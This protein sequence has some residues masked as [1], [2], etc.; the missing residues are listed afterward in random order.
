MN[1]QQN[2]TAGLD[3][4]HAAAPV[5]PIELGNL[6]VA[7]LSDLHR[8]AGD[9]ADDFRACRDAFAA[10]LDRYGRTRHILALLGDAEDLWECRPAEVIARYRASILLEKAFHDQGRY[11]RFLGNHDQAWQVPELAG[12]YLEP[13]LGRVMPL[14]LL[15]L[16]VTERGRTSRGD[17]PGSRP[18]G[19]PVGGS[20]GVVQPQVSALRL[21]PDPA[22]GE[23]EDHH[24]GHRL[25]PGAQA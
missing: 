7:I 11:W 16:L 15:R 24:P 3:R 19:R 8:G 12:E 22:P 6:R 2:I 20:A 9:D 1:Y 21:A 5:L 4:V 23:F 17:L 13:I 25:A 10:A 14:E 18:S